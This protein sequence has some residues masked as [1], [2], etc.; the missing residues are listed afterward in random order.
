VEA[1]HQLYILGPR[2]LQNELLARFAERETEMTLSCLCCESQ[3]EIPLLVDIKTRHTSM[4]LLDCEDGGLD[5]SLRTMEALEEPYFRHYLVVLF[6]VK[7]SAGIEELSLEIGVKGFFYSDDP[8]EQ[9]AKGIHM[10]FAGELWVSREILSKS[11][12]KSRKGERP[13]LKKSNPLTERETEILALISAGAK[14][15]HIADEL[16]I[17]PNTVKTHIYNIFKK[18]RV[19]NRLQAA[20]WAVK[21]L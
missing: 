9:I 1:E 17:S 4:I 13:L 7:P 16:C 5:E 20:L 19:P 18:I 14:N 2:R 12:A 11:Y 6:N 8:K 15:D 10:I 3:E 21:N